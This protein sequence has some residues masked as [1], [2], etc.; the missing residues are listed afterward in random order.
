MARCTLAEI[1]EQSWKNA[2]LRPSVRRGKG[3]D[4]CAKVQSDINEYI[5]I[6]LFIAVLLDAGHCCLRHSRC[7]CHSA[8]PLS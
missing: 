1:A 6:V 3:S 4:G 2:G 7:P 8:Q 5:Y